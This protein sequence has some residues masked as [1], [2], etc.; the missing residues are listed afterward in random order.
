MNLKNSKIVKKLKGFSPKLKW[1]VFSQMQDLKIGSRYID[2]LIPDETKKPEYDG[3]KLEMMVRDTLEKEFSPKVK[4]LK[5][6][7]LLVDAV[8]HNL[9]KKQLATLGGEEGSEDWTEA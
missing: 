3:Y 1:L 8:V 9:K 7:E 6:Y 2:Y 4:D 5:S